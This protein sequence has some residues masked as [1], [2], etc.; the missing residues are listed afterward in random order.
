VIED[1][2]STIA[3]L[4]PEGASGIEDYSKILWEMDKAAWQEVK[5]SLGNIT[6]V[7]EA[8]H[9]MLLD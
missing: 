8:G 9:I 2:F 7:L 4:K 5:D 6:I 1:N 3:I